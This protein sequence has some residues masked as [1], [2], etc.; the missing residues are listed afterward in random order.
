VA[1][2]MRLGEFGC[3]ALVSVRDGSRS[4]SIKCMER[5]RMV[6]SKG[7]KRVRVMCLCGHVQRGKGA[8]LA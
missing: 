8:K 6:E 1:R 4:R 2:D 7:R 3:R 5:W